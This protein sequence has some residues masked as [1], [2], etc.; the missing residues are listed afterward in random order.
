LSYTRSPSADGSDA[1]A[2]GKRQPVER[3]LTGGECLTYFA[4]RMTHL[5]AFA[6]ASTAQLWW[7]GSTIAARW[8]D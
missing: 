8:R 2:T 6:A 4:I 5:N 3:R 1:H 7:H